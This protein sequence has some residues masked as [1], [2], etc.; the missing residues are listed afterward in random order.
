LVHTQRKY[1]REAW[2]SSS[3]EQGEALIFPFRMCD[4]FGKPHQP[5][6]EEFMKHH[7]V[8]LLTSTFFFLLF[9]TNALAECPGDFDCD[10]DVDA[11]DLTIFV[12][13]FGREDCVS[14]P[15]AVNF[16]DYLGPVGTVRVFNVSQYSYGVTAFTLTLRKNEDST[17]WEYQDGHLIKYY[18]YRDEEY[19][20]NGVLSKTCIY[21]QP[22][23]SVGNFGLQRFGESWGNH[24]LATCDDGTYYS[25]IQMYTLLGLE[26]VTVPA[27]TFHDCLKVF[28][29]RG[30]WGAVFWFAPGLGWIKR[31]QN[32]IVYELTSY[33]M[34]K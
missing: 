15:Q 7:F 22:G 1:S 31:A 34:E 30:N 29:N 12:S 25:Y 10:G 20:T 13:D 23:D 32:G 26:D 14:C 16:D 2:N 8:I 4:T 3:G 27:G 33:T 28:R 6:K 19:D 5:D 24:W 11:Q 21:D 18:L 9:T 17:S